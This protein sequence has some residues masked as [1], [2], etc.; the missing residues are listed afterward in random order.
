MVSSTPSL[1][2]PI[3]T[4]GNA[5]LLLHENI[6]GAIFFGLK[7]LSPNLFLIGSFN[8]PNPV[9]PIVLPKPGGGEL[10]VNYRIELSTFGAD[11]TPSDQVFD[12]FSN[13]FYLA[14]DELAIYTAIIFDFAGNPPSTWSDRLL[15]RTWLKLRVKLLSS[16]QLTFSLIDV[17]IA[18]DDIKNSSLI[19]IINMILLGLLDTWALTVSVPVNLP[20]G[21]FARLNVSAVSLAL[22]A[23]DASAVVTS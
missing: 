12:G 11:I 13:P 2:P 20:L 15:I 18:I 23:L 4:A 16:G 7:R 5:R 6:I 9:S 19:H 17:N 14:G 8:V 22:D 1:T 10:R 21:D 3:V